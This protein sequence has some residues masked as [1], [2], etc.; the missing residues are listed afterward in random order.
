MTGAKLFRMARPL[1]SIA[2]LACVLW[3]VVPPAIA[4]ITETIEVR[5]T[6]IEVIATDS[7]GKPVHDLTREDFELFED[8]KRQPITNFYEVRSSAVAAE[9]V[10]AVPDSGSVVQAE[11][12]QRKIIVF[13]DNVTLGPH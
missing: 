1:S 10:A 11:Q 4:Q 13:I 2:V 5:I 8:G 6:N 12:R 3:A 7:S 9:P